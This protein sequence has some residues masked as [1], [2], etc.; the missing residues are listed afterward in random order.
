VLRELELEGFPVFAADLDLALLISDVSA[1]TPY[2]EYDRLPSIELDIALVVDRKVTAA[3]VLAVVE[4]AREAM[5]RDAEVFDVFHSEQFGPER[6]AMAIRIRL[7]AGDRTLEMP[8]AFEIR[9]RIAR[10][11]ERDLGATIRE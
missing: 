6:T 11:F 5:I 1:R 2:R 7:N 10:A 8:E 4:S 3:A 9:S